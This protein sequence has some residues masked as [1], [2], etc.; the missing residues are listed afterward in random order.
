MVLPKPA[1]ADFNRRE[2]Q[3]SLAS[4]F[5]DIA[6]PALA[7]LKL[8]K[9]LTLA[10]SSCVVTKKWKWF[11]CTLTT[12]RHVILIHKNGYD[13]LPDAVT[14]ILDSEVSVVAD[15]KPFITAPP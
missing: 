14:P 7:C 1:S 4:G 10:S 6:S 3:G 2:H 8:W 15:L 5:N 13:D 9:G 11:F 12:K